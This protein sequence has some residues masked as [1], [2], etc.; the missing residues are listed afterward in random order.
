MTASSIFDKALEL[1]EK[2]RKFFSSKK[3]LKALMNYDAVVPMK[4][5]TYLNLIKRCSD[6]GFLGEK[7]ADFL[8]YMIDLY[9]IDYLDWSHKTKWLKGEIARLTRKDLERLPEQFDLFRDE[10]KPVPVLSKT[11][12]HTTQYQQHTRR[13]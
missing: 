10:K 4:H 2:F 9:N 5:K 11:Y 6:D 1:K 7:E 12:I 3:K 13:I 8:S